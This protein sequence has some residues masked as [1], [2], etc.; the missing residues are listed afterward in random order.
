[1]RIT[2]K[3]FLSINYQIK[4]FEPFCIAQHLVSLNPNPCKFQLEKNSENETGI[5]YKALAL[6]RKGVDSKPLIT[7]SYNNVLRLN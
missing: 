3:K 6:Q 1:M 5:I 7:L 4:T 2:L